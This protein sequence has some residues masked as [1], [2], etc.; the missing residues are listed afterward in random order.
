MLSRSNS[1]SRRTFLKIAA[2]S[3]AP[4]LLAACAVPQAAPAAG[5]GAAAPSGEKV[6]LRFLA[7]DYDSNMQPDTQALV[8]EFNS[9]QDKIE[10][11]LEIVSW[12][13]GQNVILTQMSAGQPP[14][15]FNH[16]GQGLLQFQAEDQ[17]AQLDDLMGEEFLSNFWES[18]IDAMSVSGALYGMP[19]FLDPRGLFYRKDLFDAKGLKA[20]ETW[21]DVREAAKALNDPPNMY[22]FGM[23]V[24]GP[25]GSSDDWWYAWVGAIGG[26]NNLSM[27]GD[28]KRALVANEAGIRAVQYLADLV[29]TDQ[30]TQPSPVNAGRDED[31]QPLFLAGQLAMIET[32][33]WMPTIILNKAPDI[34]FDLAPLPVAEAGMTHANVFW[35]DAVMMAKAG[36]H[37]PEAAEFVKFQFN[38]DNRLKFAQQRGVIPE[39]VDVGQ[40]PAYLDPANPVSKYNAIFVKELEHAYNKFETPWPAS[41]REDEVDIENGVAKVFLGEASVEAAMQEAAA[42]INTRHG[43]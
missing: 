21:A 12:A 28:D 26:G 25:S 3:A 30:T 42:A 16:S 20:P 14:D 39:R 7:M 32:G 41:G 15:V 24:A 4:L 19:Y 40:D 9:S 18:G 13:N 6:A 37:Q 1:V 38:H 5:G 29:V 22:G 36:Q 10:T 17:L 43:L 11:A 2:A 8:D 27:W 33:S 31:L 35:P 34:Q 23:G